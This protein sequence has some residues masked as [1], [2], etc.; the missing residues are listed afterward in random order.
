MTEIQKAHLHAAL[1]KKRKELVQDIHAHA[2]R[3][4]ITE[5]EHD[6]IDVVQS[7]NQRDQAVTFLNSMWKNLANIDTALRAFDANK[8]GICDE[9][10]EE[11]ALRRLETIPWASHCVRCQE[12]LERA[13]CADIH[14][15]WPRF[16]QRDEAA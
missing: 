6:P 2:V 9:C 1:T 13:A 12:Q 3:L 4:A 11:I 8:Y 5:G 15:G 14:G 10:G 16:D 7:M